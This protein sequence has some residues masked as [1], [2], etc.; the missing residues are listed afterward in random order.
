[1]RKPALTLLSVLA[2]ASSGWGDLSLLR[3]QLLAA[4]PA[5]VSNAE[6]EAEGLP[7]KERKL[8]V[9]S[10]SISLHAN[11]DSAQA[12]ARALAH[13]MPEA[14]DALSDLMFALRYDDPAVATAVGQT[15]LKIGADSIS[16]L[17]KALDDG[18]FI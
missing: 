14:K 7:S 10:L 11:A 3:D 15:L 4:D 1:M 2:L 13:M 17:I 18:N 9:S 8:L 5:T 6:K 12:G 16:P